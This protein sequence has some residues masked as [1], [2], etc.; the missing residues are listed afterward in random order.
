[1]RSTDEREVRGRR[2][3][4]AAL[5]LTSLLLGAC[6]GTPQRPLQTVDSV[7][8]PRFMGDWYVI[9]CIPTRIERHAYSALESYRQDADGRV[10]TTFSFRDGSFDG[11][12]KR[13]QPVGF[14]KDGSKG[15]VWGMQFIWPFKSDYRVLYLDR[16][17][18]QTVIGRQKRDYAWIMARTPT[19]PAADYAQ[20]TALLT[21]QGYD[22]AELRKVPQREP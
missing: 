3:V 1:M 20:L 18:T 15:A 5:L 8:I 17:Y 10:L 21:A 9:A 12:Q 16:Q 2:L 11:P 22:I 4:V 6:P 13:Y 19:I 7:D 14:I